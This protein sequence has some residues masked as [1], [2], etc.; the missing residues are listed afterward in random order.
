MLHAE[1]HG[2][3]VIKLSKEG[4]AVPAIPYPARLS[5]DLCAGLFETADS[6]VCNQLLAQNQLK[7]TLQIKF[8]FAFCF[9][10][11]YQDL[12]SLFTKCGPRCS[13]SWGAFQ[14]LP[15]TPKLLFPRSSIY[16]MD[17]RFTYWFKEGC[18]QSREKPVTFHW[19]LM[20][21]RTT[22]IQRSYWG[23]GTELSCLPCKAGSP[24]Q[25]WG[26]NKSR[27]SFLWSQQEV[28]AVESETQGCPRLHGSRPI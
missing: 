23:L 28:E 7:E 12:T 27:G 5:F 6:W 22:L 11:F 1:F 20:G 10:L 21:Q 14:L 13:G 3:P 8:L 25:S 26:A 9:V 16:S 15:V 18:V 4:W 19:R 24:G 2:K 17:C